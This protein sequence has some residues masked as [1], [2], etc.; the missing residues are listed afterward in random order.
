MNGAFFHSNNFPYHH[1]SIKTWFSIWSTKVTIPLFPDI[2]R[3]KGNQKI[4]LDHL[5]EYKYKI[6]VEKSYTKC[7]RETIPI[8][9]SKISKPSNLWINSRL[10]FISIICFYSMPSW[11]LSTL[12]ETKL[13]TTCFYLLLGF[14][15]KQKEVWN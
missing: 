15:K 7:G 12:F 4:K 6:F 10:S 11:G 2:S 5:I 1:F 13:L 14:F 8:P 9:F 3:S